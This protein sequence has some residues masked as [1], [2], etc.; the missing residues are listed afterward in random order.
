MDNLVRVYMRFVGKTTSPSELM[1]L[2]L[3]PSFCLD[4]ISNLIDKMQPT[5][6]QVSTG[7]IVGQGAL[8]T[9]WFREK[10]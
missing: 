1:V 8:D 5:Y 2:W 7:D 4:E 3:E 10:V 6:L 9:R